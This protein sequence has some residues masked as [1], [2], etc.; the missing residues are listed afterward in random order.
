VLHGVLPGLATALS[1]V[2]Q[3]S[4]DSI[5]TTKRE[6]PMLVLSPYDLLAIHIFILHHNPLS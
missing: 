1:Q 2:V 5:Y 6:L 4:V 3:N